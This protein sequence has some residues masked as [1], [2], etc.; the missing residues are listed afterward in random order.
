MVRAALSEIVQASENQRGEDTAASC[1]SVDFAVGRR[2]CAVNAWR[3]RKA[4]ICR[5]RGLVF[6]ALRFGAREG[7][8]RT[9]ATRGCAAKILVADL[10]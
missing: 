10:L 7:Y 3:F 9:T 4:Q 6:Y 5:F 1:G 2:T 8:F